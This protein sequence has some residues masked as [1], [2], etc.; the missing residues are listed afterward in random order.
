MFLLEGWR[1]VFRIGVAL[2]RIIEPDIIRMDMIEMCQ[3]FRDSM[4][5]EVVANEF[6]LFSVAAG[7][8]VN[9]ILIHNR[10]LEKLREKFYVLQAQV[11]LENDDTW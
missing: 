11:K 1:A 9:K 4:K 2:L 5:S 3:Y 8:K 10:E 6:Q 7:V